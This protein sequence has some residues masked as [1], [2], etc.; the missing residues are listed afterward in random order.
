MITNEPIEI[1]FQIMETKE[2]AEK[3]LLENGFINIFKTAHTR[4]IYFGKDV[5]F[6]HKTEEE[7]KC[8]LIRLRGVSLFENLQLL[9]KSFPEGKVFV[10]FKTAFSYVDRMFKEGY[11][12]V[13]YTE[14]TDWI[15]EK[16]NCWHQ[17]Q[18]VK[19]V[20]LIDYVYSKDFAE[21]AKSKEEQFEMLK[22][23]ITDLGLHLKYDL[24]IDKLRTLY[25]KQIKFSKDQ[26]G[27]YAYQKK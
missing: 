12:V 3:I 1:G 9:D 27:A 4:D 6:E 5:N 10:D 7:I 11:D 26:T 22:K 8:S 16:G 18:D 24:G 13:F 25:Y 17:L 14:K 19:D 20:G 2:E 15:Y 21:I 23:H